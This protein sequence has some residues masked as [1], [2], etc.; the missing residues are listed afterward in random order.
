M[1]GQGVYYWGADESTYFGTWYKNRQN[2]CG[3]KFYPSGATE[4][5]EW[6][7]DQFLGEYTG[8][9]P[10]ETA[11]DAMQNALDTAQ[12]ARMFKYKPESE[13]TLQAREFYLHQHPTVYEEGTEWA[14]PAGTS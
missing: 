4:Y 11:Y 14:M 7:D 9:C 5:G 10:K 13:V 6:K 1:H 2:G 8:V 12:N 3:V